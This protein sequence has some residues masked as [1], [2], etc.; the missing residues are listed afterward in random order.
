MTERKWTRVLGVTSDVETAK[1]VL[2]EQMQKWVADSRYWAQKMDDRNEYCLFGSVEGNEQDYRR[3]TY[4]EGPI[5]V[6]K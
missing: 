2:P 1:T 5:E 3:K 4:V 6:T